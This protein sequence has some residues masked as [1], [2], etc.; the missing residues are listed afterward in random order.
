MRRLASGL[1][2]ALTMLAYG[3][4]E[5]GTR[6]EAAGRGH[7]LCGVS[8]GVPG[9]SERT[10]G[11][12]WKGF[13]VDL[14]R[15]V[16]AAAL[17]DASRVRFVPLDANR[18][19]EALKSGAV[20][21]LIRNSTQ[22]Y[23]RDAGSGLDTAGVAFYDGQGFLVPLKAGWTEPEQ[24]AG[25]NVCVRQGTTSERNLADWFAARKLAVTPV[26]VA[27]GPELAEAF[28]AGRCAAVTADATQLAAMRAASRQARDLDILP[29]LISKEPL[30]PFVREGD[31]AWRDLVNWTLAGLVET[32]E[33]GIAQSTLDRKL[34][35]ADPYVRTLLG[36][37]G[38][39]GRPL[40]LDREWLR[41]VVRQVG[42]YGDVFERN[43]GKRSRYGLT[44]GL[45]QLWI[46][47]GL[48]YA[49]PFR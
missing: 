46:R 22:S 14:C 49:A 33:N 45:N 30:G 47:G 4:G 24:L 19:F 3:D 26:P 31:P 35:D 16:A 40:G 18:R 8:T 38:D 43:L 28:F 13:D 17:G 2:A 6:E 21:V 48:M 15:A 7:L 36:V 32:E 34:R 41:R 44:R 11:D 29:G 20:D 1:L 27:G 9:F 39:I 37:D 10:D 42:N 5:A 23:F 25:Q 12:R